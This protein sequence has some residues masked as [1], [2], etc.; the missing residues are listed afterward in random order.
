VLLNRQRK[1]MRRST[2]K[3]LEETGILGAMVSDLL[4][5]IRVVKAYGQEAREQARA[6]GS[7][8]SAFRHHLS[9]ARARAL[10]SPIAEALT[11][12]GIALV[13]AYA[14]WRGVEGDLTLGHFMGFMTAAML[15]YQ[16][17]RAVA[18]FQTALQEGLTAA[19]RVFRHIDAPRETGTGEETSLPALMAGPGEIIFEDIDFSYG[20]APVLK[21]FNLHLRAGETVALVGPSGA[22][23]STVLDLLMRFRQP[24]SGRIL[25]DGQD[26][27]ACSRASLRRR[28]AYVSQEPV[29]F[30]DTIGANI[31]YGSGERTGAGMSEAAEQAARAAGAHNFIS[32]LPRGYATHAGEAGELLSGGERQRIAIARAFCRNA[33]ILLLDEAT[34]ALDSHSE[35]RVREAVETLKSGRTVL[36]IAHRLSTIRH[37]ARICVMQDGRIVESGDYDTLVR[38]GGPFSRLY[39]QTGD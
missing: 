14:G 20:A 13:I 26:I 1:T 4:K 25:I 7:I 36:M 10:S 17:L 23:K 35:K 28:M 38:S 37:A 32:A 34:S 39:P 2:E 30:H 18:T 8:E 27:A 21:K 22:G 33:P 31:A 9:A 29:L 5:G 11:G 24:Q 3:V 6:R 12:L 19:A 16:P 15:A